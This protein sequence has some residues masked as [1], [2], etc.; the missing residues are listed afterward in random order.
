MKKITLSLAV[1][2]VFVANA[3]LAYD[4]TINFTGK[5]IDQ[6]CEVAAG[7][8]NLTVT[9]PTV[10]K[11]VLNAPGKTAGLTPF[12]IQLSGCSAAGNNANS[13]KLY[14]EPSANV[15]LTTHNLK[16][17][18]GASGASQVEIQ[19]V[20]GDNPSQPINLGAA[21]QSVHSVALPAANGDV[22]L[23]YYAQYYATAQADAG[24]VAST[25]NY[26]IAYE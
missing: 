26:T 15:N 13:V 17:T 24:D 19:L 20:N 14:F 12:D 10:S 21:D 5:V 25:V 23:K 22:T 18:A 11:T 8:K 16:N 9:L 1:A 4:S 3:A 7:S 6:T 2:S